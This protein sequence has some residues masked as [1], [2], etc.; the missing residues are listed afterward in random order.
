MR[1]ANASVTASGGDFEAAAAEYQR[2]LTEDPDVRVRLPASGMGPPAGRATVA[3]R[4]ISRRRCATRRTT[5]VR[6]LAHLFLGAAAERHDRS[7]GRAPPFRGGAPAR[8]VPDVGGR[9]RPGRSGDGPRRSR[10]CDHRGVRAAAAIAPRIPGGTISSAA[11]SPA[12]SPGCGRRRG[13]HDPARRGRAAR[14]S[15]S[16][17]RAARRTSN[18]YLAL[19]RE[20]AAGRRRRCD[21]RA[22][23]PGRSPISARRPSVAGADRERAR[24]D[25]RRD[26][27]Y[28]PRQHHHRRAAR[29]GTISPQHGARRADRRQRPH[30][31]ARSAS[32]RS[33]GAGSA[34]WRAST[35]PP[36]SCRRHGLSCSRDSTGSPRTRVFTSP[37]A[38]SSRSPCER[39]SCLTG[40]ATPS[41]ARTTAARVEAALKTATNDYRAR[42]VDR[43]PQRGGAP[44]P[45]LGALRSS[46]TGGRR[47]ISPPRSP[48]RRTIDVRYLGAPASRRPRRA[49]SASLTTRDGSTSSRETAGPDFQTPYVAL[50]RVEQALG[51]DD[52]RPGA[53]AHRPATRQDATRTIRGGI[54]ASDSTARACTGLRDEVRRPQ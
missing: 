2:A 41:T 23:R 42:A 5:S 47:A 8:P 27:P 24:S 20:Y 37:A 1:S 12:R 28:R 15:A 29:S 18:G 48:M 30:R 7:G 6:Y 49:A 51:H 44:A 11:S 17:R 26:A 54:T 32:S 16:P 9:A 46:A 25:G 21:E 45:G 39:I 36:S 4:P 3:P 38:S 35:R 33:S 31:P 13:G 10:A 53:R 43:R 22:S 52:A 50:S 14:R 40:G 19:A 34:S